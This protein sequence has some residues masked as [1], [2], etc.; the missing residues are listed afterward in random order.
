MSYSSCLCKK[1]YCPVSQSKE[2]LEDKSKH[3]MEA[4]DV[5]CLLKS[6]IL[7]YLDSL[8]PRHSQDATHCCK[9][10][11][12]SRNSLMQLT[13][14]WAGLVGGGLS[15]RL[16]PGITHSP[17][18]RGGAGTQLPV[19]HRLSAGGLSFCPCGSPHTLECM[20]FLT[21]WQPG[22][23]SVYSKGQDSSLSRREAYNWKTLLTLILFVLRSQSPPRFK[24]RKPRPHLSS[25]VVSKKRK[26]TSIYQKD[27]II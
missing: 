1:G 13:V 5:L 17:V 25:K 16:S 14:I 10:S 7:S 9:C 23:K 3:K 21:V 6:S 4:K 24:R 2:I 22:F 12:Q 18:W 15:L 27:K 20:S 19:Q 26:P 11:S 8:L